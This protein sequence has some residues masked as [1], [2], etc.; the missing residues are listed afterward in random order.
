MNHYVK[1]D[2]G[3]LKWLLL[4]HARDAFR[5]RE[6][7]RSEWQGLNY[8][9]QPDFDRALKEY[10]QFVQIFEDSGIQIHFLPPGEETSLDSIYVRDPLIM[11]PRGAVLGNMGKEERMTEPGAL[12]MTLDTLEIPVLGMIETPGCV[13]GGDVVVFDQE[14]MAVGQGYRTNEEGIKQL[15]EIMRD[16]IKELIVVPLPHWDGPGDVLH[17]MS[18]IS[19]VDHDLAVVYSRMMPVPFRQW[20]KQRSIHFLEVPDEEYGS[21]GCNVLAISPRKCLMIKGNP[22]TKKLLEKSGVEVLEYPGK[23]I[24]L[25]GSGGPTCLTR[26]LRRD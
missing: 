23:E 22:K 25:K 16:F 11:T 6:K 8:S 1:S 10:D 5:T 3:Q 18:M 12:L 17:L 7:I 24:S 14:T 20:L 15:R 2:T 21:L 13:E 19:P 26:P 4:K 9:G